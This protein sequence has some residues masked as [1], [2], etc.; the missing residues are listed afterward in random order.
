MEV[1]VMSI[2]FMI[3]RSF[4]LWDFFTNVSC[5]FNST[6]RFLSRRTKSLI[7]MLL[8]WCIVNEW[9]TRTGYEIPETCWYQANITKTS[10]YMCGL[11]R[12]M[13]RCEIFLM[14]ESVSRYLSWRP[15]YLWSPYLRLIGQILLKIIKHMAELVYFCW[16]EL[17]WEVDNCEQARWDRTLGKRWF[18]KNIPIW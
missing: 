12:R 5:N 1:I 4:R 16:T 11:K 14:R 8:L 17:Y 3:C 13:R 18:F 15:Q 9:C 7:Q 6:L 10:W 2:S